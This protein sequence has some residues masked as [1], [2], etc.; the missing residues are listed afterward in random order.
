MGGAKTIQQ[1]KEEL[2]GAW[3]EGIDCPCCGQFVKLYRRKVTSSMARG[4]ISVY[5]YFERPNA[6]E[7]LHVPGFLKSSTLCGDF[8]KLRHWELVELQPFQERED[9]SK[10]AGY[11]RITEVGREYVRGEILIDKYR[12]EYN[13]QVRKVTDADTT[14]ASIKDALGSK[15]DYRELM[16]VA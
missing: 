13:G 12:Y 14:Q 5:H 11:Y 8:S 2:R 16:A 1:A 7:W 10:R 6:E 4:L 9:G 3:R 15:F